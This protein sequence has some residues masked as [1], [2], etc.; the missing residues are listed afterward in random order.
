MGLG[1]I[2]YIIII[3]LFIIISLICYFYFWKNRDKPC[4]GC[5][6]AKNCTNGTCQT[7]NNIEQKNNKINTSENDKNLENNKNTE[8]KIN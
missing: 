6:Y 4:H 1:L 7:K 5:P 3:S 2:D 8:I